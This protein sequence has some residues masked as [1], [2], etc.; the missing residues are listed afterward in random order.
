MRVCGWRLE[1]GAPI[2]HELLLDAAQA[3]SERGDPHLGAELAE[4]ALRSGGGCTG[5]PLLARC[6]QVR[7]RFEDAE[8]RPGGS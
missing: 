5:G 1:A 2:P 8:V 6:H 3:A 4:R 7:K